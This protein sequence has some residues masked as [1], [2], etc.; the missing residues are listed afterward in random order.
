MGQ[1][2]MSGRG[3][4]QDLPENFPIHRSQL[5]LFSNAW[6]WQH[7][8]EPLDS[9]LG[10]LDAVSADPGAGVGPGLSFADTMAEKYPKEQFGLVPCAK[11]GS[12]ISQWAVSPDRSTL[13]G[14]CLQRI[15][16]AQ[17]QGKIKGILWY[18]GETDSNTEE[19]ANLWPSRFATLVKS[20][21]SDLKLPKLPVVFAQIGPLSLAQRQTPDYKYWELVRAKQAEVS[22]PY[23]KMLVTEQLELKDDGLHLNTK[24][25][26]SLGKTFARVMQDMLRAQ[27]SQQSGHGK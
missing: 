26:L 20:I 19:N 3:L 11:G 27:E 14:S 1:S 8:V 6:T 21:R 5:Y 10:Q 12:R 25:Q 23:V 4:L 2:N 15:K 18:Q 7:A 13:Y 16:A 24:S 9:D 17:K 22:L